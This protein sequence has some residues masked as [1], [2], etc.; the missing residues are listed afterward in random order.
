MKEN[1]IKSFEEVHGI[2]LVL[3]EGKRSVYYMDDSKKI[4]LRIIDSKKPSNGY[5]KSNKWSLEEMNGT[6]DFI[7]VVRPDGSWGIGMAS[8]IIDLANA[9]YENWLRRKAT[10]DPENWVRWVRD[11]YLTWHSLP[12]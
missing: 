6:F 5:T 4:R 8:T 3:V 10:R 12:S 11:S 9:D 1:F 2:K 7:V